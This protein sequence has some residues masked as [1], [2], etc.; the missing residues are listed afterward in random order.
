M[1][2]NGNYN[3]KEVIEETAL[4]VNEDGYLIADVDL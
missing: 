2:S 3:P 1:M 4:L